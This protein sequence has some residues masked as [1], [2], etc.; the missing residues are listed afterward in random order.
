MES[1]V[2]AGTDS[3]PGG[4]STGGLYRR[5]RTT[6][7]SDPAECVEEPQV[8]TQRLGGDRPGRPPGRLY[9]DR[10]DYEA[11][12]RE[13]LDVMNSV[14]MP[15]LRVD[16]FALSGFFFSVQFKLDS[17]PPTPPAN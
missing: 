8:R 2:V 14:S 9:A 5:I 4:I 3:R 16:G 13:A 7:C 15:S 1:D 12:I 11:A 6:L 17:T 10:P